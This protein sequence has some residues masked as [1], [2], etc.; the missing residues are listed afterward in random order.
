MAGFRLHKLCGAGALVFVGFWGRG[1]GY[2][3]V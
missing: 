2:F 3:G 1:F